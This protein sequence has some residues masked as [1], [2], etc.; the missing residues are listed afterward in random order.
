MKSAV[1]RKLDFEIGHL[2]KSPCNGC[3]RRDNLPG[4]ARSCGILRRIQVVLSETI[5]CTRHFSTL[6]ASALS[7]EGWRK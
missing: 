4:C 1:Y 5:S 2:V 3:R 7:L 6:E